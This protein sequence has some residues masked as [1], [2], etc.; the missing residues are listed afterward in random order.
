MFS[1]KNYQFEIS[2]N[3]YLILNKKDM[4]EVNK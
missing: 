3:T 4:K 1:Q 2:L